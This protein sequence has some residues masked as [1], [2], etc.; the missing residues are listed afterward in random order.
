MNVVLALSALIAKRFKLLILQF[1][2]LSFSTPARNLAA[3]EWLLIQAESGARGPTLRFW[4]SPIHFVA[5]GYTNRAETEANLPVCRA[6]GVPITRRVSG[7]GTVLQGPGC[8]NYA[9]IHPIAPG[10]TLNVEATN[11]MVMETQ[12]AAFE[13]L[14]GEAVT[15]AGHT[16]LATR[17]LKFSGNAQRR[18]A[19]Y[20][21]FHGTVLLD[22]DL[23][24]VQRL[25][26]PPSKEPE[27]RA[28][29]SH[30]DFIRN[31]PVT[32]DKVKAALC[33]A[34][35]ADAVAASIE[36]AN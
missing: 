24:L 12:R 15:V 29:R 4:E 31:L 27:Y 30:R 21:L 18:K 34:W 5:L 22:F 26:R 32:R 25:L 10:E 11:K 28:Q 13:K 9:L 35:H 23:E 33:A 1:L 3:D 20:F 2:D 19:R 36:W 16:D 17:N 6:A 14:L 7:G 8:L